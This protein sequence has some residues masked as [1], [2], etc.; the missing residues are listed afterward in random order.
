MK[1]PTL[2][3]ALLLS[4]VAMA[5]AKVYRWIDGNGQVHFGQVPPASGAYETL[6]TRAVPPA[7]QES[8][9]AD[10]K[11]TNE[12]TRRFLEEADAAN[13]A[14]AEQKAKAKEERQDAQ[15]KCSEARERVTFLEERTARRLVTAGAD[16]ELER[17]PEDEFLRRLASAQRNVETYCR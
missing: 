14:K 6:T 4:S 8:A 11:S 7:S 3:A 17:L 10:A 5:D 1:L 12:D 13:R 9:A 16:G 15:R 2:L